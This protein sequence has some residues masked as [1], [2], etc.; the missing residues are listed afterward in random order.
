MLGWWLGG[1]LPPAELNVLDATGGIILMALGLRLAGIARLA[2]T[3]M[4]PA[5][6]LAPVGVVIVGL[7]T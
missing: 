5:L 7:V 1:L 3:E 2:V 4:V 6:V